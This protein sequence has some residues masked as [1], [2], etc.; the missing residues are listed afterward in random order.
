MSECG[1]D[2][3]CSA[4]TCYNGLWGGKREGGGLPLFPFTSPFNIAVQWQLDF[5]ASL[6]CSTVTWW[7]CSLGLITVSVW[8]VVGGWRGRWGGRGS[9]LRKRLSD[10]TTE[11]NFSLD[12][13][14]L[15]SLL[16]RLMGTQRQSKFNFRFPPFITITP[17]NALKYLYRCYQKLISGPL[18]VVAA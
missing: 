17:W 7:A 5:I 6:R 4:G 12:S 8:R 10:L 2:P 9:H 1:C 16:L 3:S 18:C 14:S 11:S 13:V 15:I